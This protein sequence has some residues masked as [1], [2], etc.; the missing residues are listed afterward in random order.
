[1]YKL[2]IF[3]L[4]HYLHKW[5]CL[6]SF[7]QKIYRK[8]CGF[9]SLRIL[10]FWL[11]MFIDILIFFIHF[12]NIWKTILNNW[13]RISELFLNF[14][15]FKI[16]IL[17]IRTIIDNFKYLANFYSSYCYTSILHL[18]I[19]IFVWKFLCQ[20]CCDNS[21]LISYHHQV[22]RSVFG[23]VFSS[24]FFSLRVAV[25]FNLCTFKYYIYNYKF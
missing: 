1:M 21:Q 3:Y 18:N 11:Y 16:R 9:E 5:D 2:S 14:I 13:K 12:L 19:K 6:I 24:I 17:V 8:K 25:L 20:N 15:L 7:L 4:N 10:I 22:S 23:T